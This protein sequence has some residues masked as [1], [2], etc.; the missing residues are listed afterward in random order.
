MY[1]LYIQIIIGYDIKNIYYYIYNTYIYTIMIGIGWASLYAAIIEK[2][3]T[4]SIF[5]MNLQSCSNVNK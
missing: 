1:L 3:E 4:E 5:K 2:Y